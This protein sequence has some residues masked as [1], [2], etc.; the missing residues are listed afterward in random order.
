M[1]NRISLK[2]ELRSGIGRLKSRQVRGTGKTP[3]ILYGVGT[4]QAL[5]ISSKELV[6][7][8]NAT[9]A[10]SVLV[11]LEIAGEKGAKKHLALLSEVQIHPIKDKVLHVDLHEI[12]P[13]KK[14][15][16]EVSVH[17]MGEAIGVRTGGGVLDH[18]IRHVRVECLPQDLP[19]E[20]KVDVSEMNIGDSIHVKELP[21]PKGV[22]FV[23][24]AE[25]PVFMVHA[26]KVEEAVAPGA[27]V[28]AGPE[29]ITAK[30]TDAAK[31]APAKKA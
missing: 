23:T 7:A 21:L 14:V 10:E 9:K 2:A 1:A 25:L 29:V 11:D 17:E 28:A 4:P 24:S 22:V 18:L 16:A 6:A 20:I 15:Q 31:A 5:S 30:K 8:L 3:A 19:S 27:A 12:D 26:P 13:N